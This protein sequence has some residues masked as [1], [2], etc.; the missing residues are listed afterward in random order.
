MRYWLERFSFSF[1]IVGL[2]LA[3]EGYRGAMG[4]GEPLGTGRIILYY[5]GA[6]VCFA[7]SLWGTRL[8]HHR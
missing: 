5:V 4:R 8:R 3:W 1:L 7:L 6:V 2:V